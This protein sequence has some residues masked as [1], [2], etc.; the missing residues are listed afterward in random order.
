MNQIKN[1]TIFRSIIH[2]IAD[3]AVV[4]ATIL[5]LILTVG[6][7]KPTNQTDSN[8]AVE[9][10]ELDATLRYEE[11]DT[12]QLSTL[13]SQQQIDSIQVLIDS[14]T[15]EIARLEIIKDSLQQAQQSDFY[16]YASGFT[17]DF[18]LYGA[19]IITK[20]KIVYGSGS[21]RVEAVVPITATS[22]QFAAATEA[23]LLSTDNI[24]QT[25]VLSS[26]FFADVTV[27]S[28][29]L[30]AHIPSD[31]SLSLERIYLEIEFTGD[32]R[33]DMRLAIAP[34]ANRLYIRTA[35]DLAFE[36]ALELANQARSLQGVSFDNSN[37]T[38]EQISQIA[39]AVL[40]KEQVGF[41]CL[42][43]S[44]NLDISYRDR[45]EAQGW[46]IVRVSPK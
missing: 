34:Q 16:A 27:F 21:D 19:E 5:A 44:T 38:S 23:V 41:L 2:R 13:R 37:L 26:N 12:R 28:F 43:R 17:V 25:T 10:Q 3:V 15:A 1:K 14:L 18:A 32:S 20:V 39:E 33:Y 29:D 9:L 11:D 8:D 22:E 4:L 31:Q 35:G 36:T 7:E 24:D 40:L 45:F 30:F 46:E 42:W 6:C